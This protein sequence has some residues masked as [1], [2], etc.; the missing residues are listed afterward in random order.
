MDW[1]GS[2][3]LSF[4]LVWV[5][6]WGRWWFYSTLRRAQLLADRPPGNGRGTGIIG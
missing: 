4:S 1:A 5:M 2:G 6:V 3:L